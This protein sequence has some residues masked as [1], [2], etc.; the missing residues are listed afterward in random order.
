MFYQL[1][2]KSSY[3]SDF[4]KLKCA[5]ISLEGLLESDEQLADRFVRR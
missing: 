2:V 4:L 3:L 1:V 5:I